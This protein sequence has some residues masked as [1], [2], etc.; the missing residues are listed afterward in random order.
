MKRSFYIKT[1]IISLFSMLLLAS[2]CASPT[3]SDTNN[4]NGTNNVVSNNHT[5]LPCPASEE[6]GNWL[7]PVGNLSFEVIPDEVVTLRAMVVKRT[8]DTE[9]YQDALVP[10][11]PLHFEIISGTGGVLSAED[12]LTDESGMASV[13]FSA[14]SEG[15][16]RVSVSGEG[17]C[18]R[19]Y[20][21][22]VVT[23]LVGFEELEANPSSSFTNRKISV[24]V[25]AFNKVPGEGEMPISG[26]PV[27]FE[28]TS[29]GSGS[30]LEDTNGNS[31]SSLTIDTGVSGSATLFFKTGTEVHQAKIRA[32]LVDMS[33]EPITININVQENTN[34]GACEN[35]IDCPPD[36]PMCEDGYCIEINT[37]GTCTNNDDCISPYIC[38]T[39]LEKCVP[40]TNG[41]RC[42][43]LNSANPC[44]EPEICVGGYC[45][46]PTD[47]CETNDDCPTGWL[48]N[49]GEC[50]PDN[51]G[52][53]DCY[54]VPCPDGDVCIN[55]VCVNP[56]ECDL[57][58]SPTRLAGTWNFDSMLH[59]RDA[60][61]PFLG[62]ILTAA[63]WLRDII[64]GDF[65]IGGIPS[66][67]MSI[68]NDLLQDLISTYVPQWAQDLIVA[69]GN[70]SDIVDDMRVLHTVNLVPMGND[71]Y[72]GTQVWDLIEF[73]YDGQFVTSPPEDV[74]GFEVIPDDF[75]SREICGTFYIDRYYIRNVV[76]GLVSWAI[77]V[78]V[79]GITCG[80]GNT[81]YYSLE[82][83]LY[84]VIDCDAIAGAIDDLV[85]SM[86]S[87]APSV[88]DPIYSFCD[89]Q[90]D[91]AISEIIDALD[92]ITVNL[93]L[94]SLRGVVP[95]VNDSTMEPGRWYGSLAGGNFDGDFTADK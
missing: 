32:T 38:D 35:N 37:S 72:Y 50:I 29:S 56:D 1:V 54:T 81:C 53:P 6:S 22:N 90:K 42:N 3:G 87:D 27:L 48:C 68:I 24:G 31:G 12:V 28:I 17:V 58:D 45:Q 13:T 63:E 61:G 62:G 77:D 47:N 74:L 79:T 95:I 21:V 89:S 70:V 91:N 34:G 41:E 33:V 2:G 60:V 69:L 82:E 16:Y 84:D 75:T 9:N 20:T 25:K 4:N 5:N 88:Y 67:L 8:D 94:L 92:D 52:D 49:D 15:V 46:D 36:A 76:G 80:Y 86:W 85:Y 71:E 30:I 55:G 23:L 65:Q 26:A 10:L 73:E 66:W 18:G 14:P 78:I 40:P 59:L 51:G 43:L 39:V 57:N 44:P 11:F 7:V 83:A 19:Q 64:Q 93:N